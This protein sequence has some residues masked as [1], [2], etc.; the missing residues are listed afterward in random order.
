MLTVTLPRHRWAGG[1]R[2]RRYGVVGD[3]SRPGTRP[4]SET[5]WTNNASTGSSVGTSSWPARQ[6][7]IWS[8]VQSVGRVP[9]QASHPSSIA[10]IWAGVS[11]DSASGTGSGMIGGSVGVGLP[12]GAPVGLPVGVPV[13]APVGLPVGFP[14]GSPVGLPV[15]FPVG[16]PVGPDGGLLVG[17]EVGRPDGTGSPIGLGPLLGCAVAVACEVGVDV[18]PGPPAGPSVADRWGN[19]PIWVVLGGVPTGV[20]TL[21]SRSAVTTDITLVT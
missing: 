6:V 5:H 14:V 4:S 1:N 15:G 20:I 11:D 10:W 17:W 12:V 7:C 21:L 13:G 19:S 8:S 16:P 3:S 9:T 2:R 18:G